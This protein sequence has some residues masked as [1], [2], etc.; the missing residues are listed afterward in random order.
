M[1]SA[2]PPPSMVS[3]P[4]PAVMML[5]ED[6]PVTAIAVAGI[7]GVG[8][9]T[10]I[11]RIRARPANDG[12]GRCGSGDRYAL[13]CAKPAGVDILEARYHG[14]IA[15]CLIDIGEIDRRRHLQLQRIVTAAAV[16]GGFRTTVDDDRKSTRLN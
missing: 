9:A 2:P 13:R 16:D 1:T 14:T 3:L 5:A 12:V 4:E 6:E 8:S 7:G 11:D 10:T 15:G